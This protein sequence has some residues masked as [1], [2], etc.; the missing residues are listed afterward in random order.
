MEFGNMEE[1]IY[2]NLEDLIKFNKE[3][4]LSLKESINGIEFDEHYDDM[5]DFEDIINVLHSSDYQYSTSD[6][7]FVFTTQYPYEKIKVL[8]K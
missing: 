1:Q 3:A 5:E 4:Y 2:S 8:V 7:K 6:G